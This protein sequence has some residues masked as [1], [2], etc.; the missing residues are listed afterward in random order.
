MSL[1]A[2]WAQNTPYSR[3]LLA[4]AV[5]LIC[6]VF[7]GLLGVL[8]GAIIYDVPLA[9]IDTLM[10]D[11]S[12]PVALSISK[13]VQVIGAIG[14]FFI[15]AFFLGWT[16]DGN[17]ARYLGLKRKTNVASILLVAFT[18]LA[19]FP[20]VNWLGEVNS[21]LS[22][23]SFLSGVERWIKEMEERLAGVQEE[24]LRSTKF[25]DV[26]F[27]VFM[28]G[29]LPA[30]GEE[31][32]FRGVVLRLFRELV[33]N[34]HVAVWLTAILF[35]AFHMQ[36]YGFLPRMVL[37]A[38]LG[39]LAV[40]SGS[41]WLSMCAH[42]VNNTAILIMEWLYRKN[43]VTTDLD[44]VGLDQTS[45]WLPFSILLVGVLIFFIYRREKQ[46]LPAG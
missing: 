25:S 19:A 33:S 37:G 29:L 35:S 1:K 44:T 27:N 2:I 42:F 4:A 24:L 14:I 5:I 16:F 40:W 32:L 6:Y 7:F 10:A 20:L 8:V 39:Y 17:P 13:L 46:T 30:I 36:F 43:Q 34:V 11:P 21:H 26:L 3:F 41:L 38:F 15:P 12:N 45:S 22:L 23:P 9:T 18:I 28:I 31:L